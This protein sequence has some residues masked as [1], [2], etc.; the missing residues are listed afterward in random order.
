MASERKPKETITLKNGKNVAIF[1][2]KEKTTISFSEPFKSADIEELEKYEKIK[3]LLQQRGLHIP[4]PEREDVVLKE[5]ITLENEK[6]CQIIYK[7]DK[8]TVVFPEEL[9]LEDLQALQKHKKT[10]KLT[11]ALNGLEPPTIK[12]KTPRL[13]FNF[14]STFLTKDAE[15]LKKYLLTEE[16]IKAREKA[17]G[18]ET[19]VLSSKTKVQ[20]YEPTWETAQ[21]KEDPRAWAKPLIRN[22]EQVKVF[23]INFLGKK[24]VYAEVA[25]AVSKLKFLTE[26]GEIY[27]PNGLAINVIV[28]WPNENEEIVKKTF[29]QRVM[30]SGFNYTAVLEEF[31]MYSLPDSMALNQAN[32][33]QLLNDLIRNYEPSLLLLK[34]AIKEKKAQALKIAEQNSKP[35]PVYETEG[36]SSIFRTTTGCHGILYASYVSAGATRDPSFSLIAPLDPEVIVTYILNTLNNDK[37]TSNDEIITLL[38]QTPPGFFEE[39]MG[40]FPLDTLTQQTLKEFYTSLENLYREEEKVEEKISSPVSEK[41]IETEAP[42]LSVK[43]SEIQNIMQSESYTKLIEERVDIINDRKNERFSAYKTDLLKMQGILAI[44]RAFKT[45]L[46]EPDKDKAFNIVQEAID[47]NRKDVSA[48]SGWFSAGFFSFFH[49]RKDSDQGYK[50]TSEELLETLKGEVVSR[51]YIRLANEFSVNTKKST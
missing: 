38:N 31:S 50:S 4:T 25:E 32:K 17:R 43:N 6:Q 9:T 28:S 41:M 21:V 11:N 39:F 18:Y 51:V 35:K 24:P 37:L 2:G 48:Y 5:K 47:K 49:S 22:D 15:A 14:T 1:Y 29:E 19:H 34:L 44:E 10:E 26:E 20:I 33:K 27:P 45:A 3:P 36:I 8:A 12:I 40:Q 46:N 7:K 30:G 13:R 42:S 23:R 16:D